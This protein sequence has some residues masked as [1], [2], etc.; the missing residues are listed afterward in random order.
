[1]AAGLEKTA[2][3]QPTVEGKNE[4]GKLKKVFYWGFIP[5]IYTLILAWILLWLAGIDM[6]K[7]TQIAWGICKEKAQQWRT[8]KQNTPAIQDQ[9][10]GTPTN[11]TN[12]ASNN[13]T[14]GGTNA[15]GNNA[16][17]GALTSTGPSS[18]TPKP[19]NLPNVIKT[20]SKMDP[21]SAAQVVS[22]MPQYVAIAIL[23]GLSPNDQTEILSAMQPG[24]AA[25]YASA[26]AHEKAIDSNTTA[27]AKLTSST[28]NEEISSHNSNDVQLDS[29]PTDHSLTNVYQHMK[30][31]EIATIFKGM[32]TAEVIKQAKNLDPA[33]LAQVLPN[34]DPKVASEVVAHLE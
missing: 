13:N 4:P 11:K 25:R 7:K 22:D 31:N 26:L 24:S 15:A 28:G 27:G 17:N 29:I 34:L 9:A 8:K 20:I 6:P 2:D 12:Q 1:M 16:K 5:L 33:T 10:N 32:P 21:K 30:A 23:K 3:E 18:T 19:S 14:S